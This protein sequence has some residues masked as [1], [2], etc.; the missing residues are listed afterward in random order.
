MPSVQADE[1]R[2]MSGQR[3]DAV[4]TGAKK[5]KGRA[6]KGGGADA[7]PPSLPTQNGEGDQLSVS[8]GILQVRRHGLARCQHDVRFQQWNWSCM[9]A[10]GQGWKISKGSMP[11]R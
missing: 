2:M 8:S 9:S 4:C 7:A 3:Q 10:C 5:R 1:E 6:S 11:D